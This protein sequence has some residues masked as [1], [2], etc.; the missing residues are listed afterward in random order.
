MK[1]IHIAIPA[2]VVL[3][4]LAAVRMRKT[5]LTYDAESIE[6]L[7]TGFTANGYE[8]QFAAP[9]DPAFFCPGVATTYEDGSSFFSFVRSRKDTK[10]DV[11][12]PAYEAYSGST[13]VCIPY[14]DNWRQDGWSVVI[15][16][17]DGG[18]ISQA[19]KHPP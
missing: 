5:S 7:A 9:S 19:F 8:V 15:Y 14:P 2:L 13:A 6:I 16:N 10:L 4:C 3:A 12:L 17:E 1:R 18:T 11:D